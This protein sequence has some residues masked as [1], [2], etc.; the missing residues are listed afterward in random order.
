MSEYYTFENLLTIGGATAFIAAVMAALT[1]LGGEKIQPYLKWAA[2]F[3]AL[4][5]SAVGAL[6]TTPANWQTWIVAVVNAVWLFLAAMGA[7]QLT[8]RRAPAAE[9]MPMVD[10]GAEPE[11]GS[12][13]RKAWVSW[14]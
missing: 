7:N 9:H 1:Y 5:I 13:K 3:V 10:A 6:A 12:Q 8:V 2:L 14:I 4:A 11:A